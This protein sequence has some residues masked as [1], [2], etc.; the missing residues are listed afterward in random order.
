MNR[1]IVRYITSQGRYSTSYANIEEVMVRHLDLG[2]FVPL[3]AQ[4]PDQ[5]DKVVVLTI[6]AVNAE[7]EALYAVMQQYTKDK[8]YAQI[9]GRG[10][11]SKNES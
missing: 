2:G 4:L 8:K 3:L 7:M 1:I 6:E 11:R 5:S 9:V 10:F